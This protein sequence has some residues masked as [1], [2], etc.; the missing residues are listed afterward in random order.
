MMSLSKDYGVWQTTLVFI[1]Y[2]LGKL[3]TLL[4]YMFYNVEKS[5][6]FISWGDFY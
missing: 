1:L 4:N 5:R 6:N 2:Q 3:L